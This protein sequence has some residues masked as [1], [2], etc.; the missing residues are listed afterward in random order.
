M[1]SQANP[2]HHVPEEITL[3]GVT[4]D[5]Q[6]VLLMVMMGCH[7]RMER[8]EEYRRN[9][10]PPYTN[11]RLIKLGYMIMVLFELLEDE[12]VNYEDLKRKI[13]QAEG[14]IYLTELIKVYLEVHRMTSEARQ[15]FFNHFETPSLN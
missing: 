2:L 6:A 12:Y 11:R 15:R 7:R 10:H 5:E 9:P 4:D 1:S 14:R 8:F 13:A 3:V